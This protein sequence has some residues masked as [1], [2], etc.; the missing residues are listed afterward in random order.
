MRQAG[1]TKSRILDA[2]E[3]LFGEHGFDGTSLRAITSAGNV[4]LAAVNYHFGSKEKLMQAVFARHL[5]PLNAR[6]LALLDALEA[7]ACGGAVPIKELIHALIAPAME[8]KRLPGSGG[9]SL[10]LLLGRMY[11]DPSPRVRQIFVGE[12]G[13]I[14]RRFS[15]ALRRS[16]PGVP[17]VE[18]FWRI[19]FS[20]G[21]MA[22]TLAG[23]W[24][25]QMLSGGLCDPSDVDATTNR[26]VAFV[27]AG[28]QAPIPVGLEMKKPNVR[29][30]SRQ[31]AAS[32]RR[33][34]L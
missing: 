8:L 12:L 10:P 3:H 27:S 21:A 7:K 19:S 26:L 14:A 31:G 32:P 25:T 13:E 17:P 5:A 16:L 9:T 22:H 15:T 2:A 23:S 29:A 34:A 4:N 30:R 24:I 18:V 6:R 1:E 28:L 20:I 11:S 33:E